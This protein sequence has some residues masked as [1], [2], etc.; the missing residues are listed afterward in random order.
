[1]FLSTLC[2][3]RIL[4]AILYSRV[5]IKIEFFICVSNPADFSPTT[6]VHPWA[7]LATS[8]FFFINLLLNLN[9][10]KKRIFYL[11]YRQYKPAV[12]TPKSEYLDVEIRKS[13]FRIFK[14]DNVLFEFQNE[15]FRSFISK[16]TFTGS[17]SIFFVTWFLFF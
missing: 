15:K 6:E 5:H 7:V 17:A 9:K 16:I 1:M 12:V 14:S 11:T 8:F 13:G 10:K 2:L 3:N 4:L